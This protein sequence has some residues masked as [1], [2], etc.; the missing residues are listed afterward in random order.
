MNIA[1]AQMKVVPG[2]PQKNVARMLEMIQQAKQKKADLIVFPEMCVGG[3]LV[4]DLWRDESFCEALMQY[5]TIFLEASKGIALAYGNIFLDKNHP[6]KDGTTRKYNAVYV[7]QN[8]AYAKRADHSFLPQGIHIKTLLPNYRFFDDERYFFSLQDVAK[9]YGIS[10]EELEQPFLVTINGKEVPLGFEICEDLW[11]ENYRYHGN[12]LNPTKMLIA[13]GAQ[14]IVNISASP[15]T[16]G[17]NHAR[18]KR[19]QFLKQESGE[20]FVP[21]FY[22]NCVG[23]QNNGKNIITFDGGSTVYNKDSLPVLF[24]KAPYQEEMII[25]DDI[26]TIPLLRKENSKIAQKYDAIIQGINSVK[27]M[28]GR[29]ENPPFVIGLSGGIDSSVVAA[30]VVKAVGKEKVLGVNMPTAFNAK[31]TQDTAK[32]VAEQLGIKY[33]VVPI[34]E[35]T[36]SVQKIIEHVI[37]SSLTPMQLGNVMAKIRATDVLSNLAAKMGG[38][39]TNNGNKDEVIL[40]YATLYGDVG[41]VLAPIA[42]LTKKEVVE[43]AH[44][45][46]AEVYN[47]K[48]I[49]DILLPDDL[50]RFAADQIIP[51]AEL[52]K[53]QID[54]MKFGYHC[55][56]IEAF[57]D[58]RRKCPETIMG[59][60]LEGTLEK[61]LHVSLELLQR[62]KIDDPKEFLADLEWFYKKIEG[63]VFKR[64]QSP[65]IIVVS[66]SAYGFDIRESMI[67]YDAHERLQTEHYKEL[68]Q[69]I[70][71]L[72]M[73]TSK[74]D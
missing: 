18:D 74:K 16:Y 47:K 20:K 50:F 46:N 37:P 9:D 3:Y 58:F 71:A 67:G 60:Y 40:G 27:E 51:S 57:T 11:C 54:P 41:G 2:R 15:W 39:F 70:L 14:S 63:A 36:K 25:V 44:Y 22:V 21:F 17:K 33:V 6:N 38:V 53:N 66:K 35:Q 73:Y 68:K 26:N 1:L 59:W 7:M 45:L 65:P 69:Q 19:I 64:V 30:L 42:D 23:V 29:E 24:S 8:G 5:N 13:N 55:A 43:M 62:W 31:K 72:S 4:G 56:L 10:L 12:A 32:Y 48:V 52:E 49:P 34:E 61:H 28:L